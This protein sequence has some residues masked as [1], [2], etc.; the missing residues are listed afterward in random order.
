MHKIKITYNTVDGKHVNDNLLCVGAVSFKEIEE[1]VFDR[2]GNYEDLRIVSI[3]ETKGE[4][5]GV[6]DADFDQPI[7]KLTYQYTTIDEVSAKERKTSGVLYV[8]SEDV[9]VKDKFDEYCK[10][11]ASDMEILSIQKSGIVDVI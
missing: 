1:R 2:Y 10:G 11:S 5:Y 7:Y 3:G 4:I 9:D 6:I 8:Q